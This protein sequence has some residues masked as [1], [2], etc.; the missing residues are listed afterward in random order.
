MNTQ[1]LDRLVDS[2]VIID[3]DGYKP[4]HF[5]QFPPDT[6]GLFAYVSARKGPFGRTLF[7]GLQYPLKRYFSRP[8]TRED[9]D[10]AQPFIEGGGM[11]F[12]REGWDYIVDRLGG[13]IPLEICA[14][15]EGTLVPNGIPMVTVR[16]TDPKVPWIADYF[17]APILRGI[18]YPTSVAT[19]SWAIKNVIRKALVRSSENPDQQLLFKLNDFGARGVSSRE[20]AGLGG[21]AH[22]VNFQGSDTLVSLPYAMRYYDAQMEIVSI[23]ASEHGTMTSWGRAG[24]VDAYRNMIRAFAGPGKVYAMVVDAYNVYEAIE[25]HIGTTLRDEIVRAQGTLVVRP[26]SGDP[27]QMSVRVL[28][29]LDAKFGSTVNKLGF[30]VL[31]GVRMIYGDGINL[32]SIQA[33]LDA[34]MAV[35]YS[36][37]NIAFGMGGALLQGPQRDDH[38][39]AMK[40]AALLASGQWREVYKDPVTDPGKASLRGVVSSYR[41][42]KTGEWRCMLRTEAMQH[43]EFEDMLQ[44][45]WRNGT[46]LVDQRF[47]EVRDR[48]R[49]QTMELLAMEPD[50]ELK[51]AA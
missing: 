4:S 13:R 18:W 35:G 11:P 45:V 14:V 21:M 1:R 25:T 33:I 42:R 48:V 30:K 36:V 27:V 32:R 46:L 50:F 43:P 41:S 7:F 37:E 40:I 24:E 51:L 44:P 31:N 5:L 22:R 9:V 6:E 3:T 34:I 20:S 49:Q 12:N 38:S 2:N 17:E 26:D 8:L 29:M 16:S 15:P 19:L 47:N 23:P 39:M 28:Q 10:D